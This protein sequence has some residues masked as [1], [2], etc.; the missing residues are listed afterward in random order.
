MT[1]IRTVQ[2]LW[3]PAFAAYII[4]ASYFMGWLGFAAA[5]I[6]CSIG[7]AMLLRYIARHP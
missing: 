3:M 2:F 1:R 4:G 7:L 6:G 5:A